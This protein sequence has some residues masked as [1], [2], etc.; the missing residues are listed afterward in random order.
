MAPL[1]ATD[2]V[3]RERERVRKWR[4]RMS[5]A[6]RDIGRLP[7]IRDPRRRRRAAASLREFC[8]AYLRHSFTKPFSRDHLKVIATM[9]KCVREGGLFALAMPRG[10]GKT[11]LC[12]AAALWAI[13]NGYHRF[14]VLIGATG[15]GAKQM[16]DNIKTELTTNELLLEDYPEACFPIHALEGITNR[17]AGQ[18][19][20]GQPTHIG[21]TNTEIV[22]PTIADSPSSGAI[23]VVAGITAGS[24]RGKKKQPKGKK[25]ATIRPTLAIVDDP[26]TDKSAKS[27]KQCESRED[28]ILGAVLGM[29]GPGEKIACLMPCTVIAQGDLADRFLD[30]EIHPSWNGIR[31]KTLNR[32]PTNE[33]WWEE[34][35]ERLADSMRKHNDARDATAFYKKNRKTADAGAEAAWPERYRDD[36]LS[37]IQHAMNLYLRNRAAFMAEHQNEPINRNAATEVKILTA[38]EIAA[39]V[40]GCPRGELPPEV[41]VLTAFADVQQNVLFWVVCGWSQDFE[42]FVVDYGTWPDQGRAYFTLS[43]LRVT[44]GDKFPDIK[45][46]EGRIYA[47]CKALTDDLVAREFERA[48]GAVLHLRRELIDANWGLS[49]KT[50]KKFCRQ[51]QHAALLLP[52][53]GRY[54]GATSKPISQFQKKPG[55]QYG[56]EWLISRVAN[57]R[58]IRHI[59][60][61]TN[62]WKSF[63]HAR[64]AI[65]MGSRGGLSLFGKRAAE[66]RMLADHLVAEQPIRVKA[67]GR[68]VDEWKEKPER[69]DNH[70]FD[71]LV[72]CAVAASVEGCAPLKQTKDEKPKPTRP[73][74]RRNPVQYFEN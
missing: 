34:Y 16:L 23:L 56:D 35:A 25:R 38:A 60:F 14:V 57:E 73:A 8:L 41:S 5:A 11:T 53:H 33:A 72:G 27:P 42:G 28:T 7:P 49:T 66:H 65:P 2:Y 10:S 13:L 26:Q 52:S 74:N 22:L 70:W 39:K 43:D 46:L 24:I 31:T 47:A 40:N 58:G 54:V 48:D 19:Y 20:N 3:K 18:R 37:A 32:F 9:E 69:P 1:A 50:V 4:A 15:S 29:A 68:E 21:W 62:Y 64:L 67:K 36:E 59:A 17:A 45:D 63:V 12:E 55:E 44:I 30:R 61:D 71:C 6:G 51:S